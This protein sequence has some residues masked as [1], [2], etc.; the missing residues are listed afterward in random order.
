[1][2]THKRQ[3]SK[4]YQHYINCTYISSA[5]DLTLLFKLALTSQ[6]HPGQ[7]IKHDVQL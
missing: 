5:L 4:V 1:M 2:C 6:S 3:N 7:L